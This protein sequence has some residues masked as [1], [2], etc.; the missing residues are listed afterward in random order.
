MNASEEINS[1][2]MHLLDSE[3]ASNNERTENKIDDSEN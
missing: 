1:T 3:M 2:V